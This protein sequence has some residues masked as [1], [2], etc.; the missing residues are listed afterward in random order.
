VKT[1]PHVTLVAHEVGTSGGME[2]QLG[3]LVEA[4]LDHDHAVTVVAGACEVEDHPRLNWVRVP[5]PRRPFS[6]WYL[7]FFIAGSVAVWIR[8]KGLVHTT[9]AVVLNR[10]DVSTVH[11]CHRAFRRN[12]GITRA[13]RDS[14]PYR[15]NAW[16][17]GVLSRLA[18]RYCYRPTITRRLAAVSPGLA[19]ELRGLFPAMEEAVEVIPNAID[20]AAF[21]RDEIE[22]A[23]R[24]AEWGTAEGELVALFVG[25]DWERKGLGAAIEGVGATDG[26]SL[27]VVGDGDVARYA[28]VARQ[29][30]AAGR[31]RFEGATREPAAYYSAAD[32]FVLPTAYETFSLVT[33]EAAAAGLPL[34]VSRVSGVEEILIDGRNGWFIDGDGQAIA[35][36]LAELRRDAP[37]R[38]AMAEAARADSARFDWG[39]SVEGYRDLYARLEA[40]R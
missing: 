12:L 25:G 3:G 7:W 13:S 21:E 5:G 8:R 32:A 2:A 40:A 29:A 30:G 26:W 38:D 24:R 31:V 37:L 10:S 6:V 16:L 15:A 19:R 22:R 27:V 14:A 20:A 18:E 1:E 28:A 11:F 33:F 35:R 39:R 4:L 23:R 36:R 17:A 9:G 34:L